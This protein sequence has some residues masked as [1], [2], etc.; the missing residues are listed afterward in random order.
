M[1][2]INNKNDKFIFKTESL[3]ETESLIKTN[4]YLNK[5]GIKSKSKFKSKSMSKSESESESASESESE[6]ESA[7]ESASESESESAS[8]SESESASEVESE[9]K[10]EYSNS[11]ESSNFKNNF[12][13]QEKHSNLVSDINSSSSLSSNSNSDSTKLSDNKK[14]NNTNTDCNTEYYNKIYNKYIKNDKTKNIKFND[15][16]KDIDK[17]KNN[18]F[19]ISIIKNNLNEVK[20]NVNSGMYLFKNENSHITKICSNKNC[21]KL[22]CSDKCYKNNL[23]KSFWN[24]NR[25]IKTVYNLLF[26]LLLSYPIFRVQCKCCENYEYL[27]YLNDLDKNFTANTFNIS[28]TLNLLKNISNNFEPTKNLEL[29]INFLINKFMNKMEILDCECK[30]KNK[31]HSFYTCNYLNYAN[32]IKIYIGTIPQVIKLLKIYF[33]IKDNHEEL[34]LVEESRCIHE[35]IRHNHLTYCLKEKHNQ[36]NKKYQIELVMKL[37]LVNTWIYDCIKITNILLNQQ[38]LEYFMYYCE[39]NTNK[40]ISNFNKIYNSSNDFIDLNYISNKNNIINIINLYWNK[41][42]STNIDKLFLLIYKQLINRNKLISNYNVNIIIINYIY[43]SIKMKNIII[44]FKW[45]EYIKNTQK[46]KLEL[47]T[48]SIPALELEKIFNAL[49]DN[50]IININTKISYLKIINKNK[51]NIIEYDFVNKLID[52]EIGDKIIL[53]FDKEEN[54]LFNI[55]DYKNETYIQEIIKKCIIKNKV[56]ILDYI[57][58]NLNKSIIEFNI[59]IILIYLINIPK[60]YS[61]IECEFKYI[62]LLKI[63]IKYFIKT[64]TKLILGLENKK[65]TPIEYCIENNLYLSAHIFIQNSIDIGNS[66]KKDFD[67]LINCFEK[68]NTI[69]F[70]YILLSNP[71]IISNIINGLNIF[72]YLFL[73]YEKK[74]ITNSNF[75][76]IFLFKILKHIDSTNYG[77]ELINYKDELNELI[78]FK[79]L[80]YEEFNSTEKNILFKLVIKHINPLEQNNTFIS[81]NKNTYTL[82]YPLI[83]HSMLID[84]L[85]ITFILLNN[86]LKNDIVKK[87]VI[88]NEKCKIYDYYLLNNEININFIPIIFKY[89]KDN[90][91]KCN[92]FEENYFDLN[93]KHIDIIPNVK[94]SMLILL[95]CIKFTLF[96]LTKSTY[97]CEIKNNLYSNNQHNV[98]K[99]V[100]ITISSDNNHN[101]LNTTTNTNT[102]TNKNIKNIKKNIWK[103]S[104]SNNKTNS[105]LYD[106]IKISNNLENNLENNINNLYKFAMLD[107]DSDSDSDSNNM[108]NMDNIDNTNSI[109]YSNGLELSES[110]ILFE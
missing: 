63:I 24:F 92:K 23:Y 40:L 11:I 21:V 5:I 30:F 48:N 28:N 88:S 33:E 56:N 89:I 39:N 43:E 99:Y 64:N 9:S 86:L 2:N 46:N 68:S 12:D 96:Y 18:Y 7:S 45:L 34:I 76:F 105:Q 110:D 104:F 50:D 79:I 15:E 14:N 19:D 58:F 94:N 62:E 26:K 32:I 102:I 91:D 59:D 53:E 51:I 77:I 8:E 52:L 22:S 36:I 20:K 72:T 90:R 69:I 84:E 75:I 1:N 66:N 93:Y 65:Y 101:Q 10:S 61:N 81:K 27:N 70:E 108:N 55:N 100:E 103:S 109:E 17:K 95:I 16:I 47:K 85:E 3:I 80:N 106:S 87:N 4:S 37:D 67:L 35:D 38:S 74:I 83:I 82:N 107:S 60:K 49:L 6:S 44:A 42:N 71:K 73:Y 57:L 31:Y 98:N 97:N 25:G 41:F 54:S 13:K 78:G 29:N